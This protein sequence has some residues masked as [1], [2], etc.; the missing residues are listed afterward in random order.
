[1]A[2]QGAMVAS[3]TGPRIVLVNGNRQELERATGKLSLL[4]FDK[5]TIDLGALTEMRERWRDTNERSLD[6]L[7]TADPRL[8]GERNVKKF[9]IEGHERVASVLYAPSLTAIALLALLAGSPGRRGYARRNLAAAGGAL[10][11]L[12]GALW[13]K[14]LGA[15][16]SVAIPLI[17][18]LVVMPMIVGLV[19]LYV[20]RRWLRRMAAVLP[21]PRTEPVPT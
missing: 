16:T 13:L 19:W 9:K 17:Y 6:E 5:Y 10:V 15:K 18:T 11:V 2:E 8:V 14:G 1:M 4:H 3:A 20:P 7:L 12:A 21:V